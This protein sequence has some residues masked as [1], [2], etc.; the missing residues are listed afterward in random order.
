MKNF[1]LVIIC[2][3]FFGCRSSDTSLEPSVEFKKIPM[4]EIGGTVRLEPIE[5]LVRIPVPNTKSFYIQKAANGMFS[6]LPTKLLPKFCRM[7]NGRISRISARN[8][9]LC[10]A[11]PESGI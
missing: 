5:G 11:L 8:T 1:C 3:L 7:G 10:S 4:A 6:R 2:V 9:P